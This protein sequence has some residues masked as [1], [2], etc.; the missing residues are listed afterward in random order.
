M[1]KRT[2]AEYVRRY[3]FLAAG[4]VLMA[5][6]VAFS[7]KANLGTAPLSS[8]PYVGNLILQKCSPLISVGL[9]ISVFYFFCILLQVLLL[10][11]RYQP[12]QLIQLPVTI[13]F[14]YMTDVALMIIQNLPCE[15]YLTQAVF[16]FIGIVL[17]SIGSSFEVIADVTYIAGDGTIAVLGEISGISF[18]TMAIIFDTVLVVI[19]AVLSIIFLKDIAGVREGTL[20]AAVLT[21]WIIKIF[22]G[23][24]LKPLDDM[25]SKPF[26]KGAIN[27]QLRQKLSGSPAEVR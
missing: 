19:A 8:L 1:K 16:C 20:A 4:L 10:R 17:V 23:Y 26:G 3:L 18:G 15:S 5:F 13:F 2:A 12:I 21:G 14:G 7:I 25:L 24:F 9:M 22:N 27:S 11:R 6:G